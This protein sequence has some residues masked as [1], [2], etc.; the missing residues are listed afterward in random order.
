MARAGRGARSGLT[1]DQ[2]RIVLA[3]VIVQLG[4]LT[5]TSSLN[6]VLP[7]MVSDF[8][9]TS[10]EEA[11][12]RQISSIASLFVVFIAGVLGPR[13][14]E[15]KV[16]MASAA[17]FI[18]GS[19]IVAAAPSMAVVTLG[20]L[21][22]NVGKAVILVVA[23]ALLTAKI[24]D[25][26]GRATAFATISTAVP[27]AYLVMP[28]VAGALVSGVGWRSVALIWALC[29][30]AAMG[31][32]AR[33]LP[34]DGVS[35]E[36][37][38]MWTPA[39]AGVVLATGV[40]FVSVMSEGGQ[41]LEAAG[42]GI[43]SACALGV[44]FVVHRRMKNPSLSLAP[45]RQGG[46]LLLLCIV[47]LFSFT[48]LYYYNTLLYEICY[49]YSALGAAVLMIPTQC[50]SIVG[51]I[52][53]RKLLQKRGVT[54]TGAVMM[55]LMGLMMMLAATVNLDSPLAWPVVL[56]SLYALA[57]VGAFVALTNAVMNLAQPG[58]EGAASSFKTAA[59]NIGV[60]LGIALMTTVVVFTGTVTMRGEM[61]SSG[62]TETDA[63]QA[64]WSILEGTEPVDA[65]DL[66]GIPVKQSVQIQQQ[67]K[68]AFVA[69][70]QAQGVVG[71]F[72][73]LA[74]AL[75][76]FI[77]RRRHERRQ[78]PASTSRSG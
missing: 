71:G 43:V 42:M 64:A 66:Y 8:Q 36:T 60:T 63:S 34:K 16:I 52:A 38:E 73:I 39:L 57:S 55:A 78:V 45:L 25:Q 23:L 61:T 68:V 27:I 17:I 12:C 76:F 59:S 2:R 28:I 21:I 70:Y 67:D 54:F 58:E 10:S 44:L 56:V 69:A 18:L 75:L 30:L 7:A 11:V 53:V 62:E 46:V 51:A 22:A 48:N 20:L 47:I 35:Q 31:A 41:A 19:L 77:E 72:I 24:Q 33:L 15:R 49:G 74:T 32:A 50:G 29:G 6:Y 13:L 14:G 37:G 5:L 3:A 4:I 9:A 65:A 1:L 40:E 26:D